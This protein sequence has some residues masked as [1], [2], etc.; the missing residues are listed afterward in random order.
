MNRSLSLIVV[1]VGQILFYSC[2]IAHD[3]KIICY[4]NLKNATDLAY[5]NPDN[6]ASLDSALIIVNRCMK[7]DSIK[8]AVV[9][10]KIRLLLTLGKFKE[11]SDFIDSLQGTDFTY[12]YKKSLN[13]DN[14]I[15]RNFASN[16]DTISHDSTYRKMADELKTYIDRNNLKSKEFQEAF[17][18]LNALTEGLN[19]STISNEQIDSLKLKYPNETQFLDFFK[20]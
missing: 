17:T 8:A 15:A 1:I 3:K 10:L 4:E 7:C 6:K 18:D 16:K 11:G 12:A 9:D 13:H 20:H 19:H 14:F 2:H 5:K